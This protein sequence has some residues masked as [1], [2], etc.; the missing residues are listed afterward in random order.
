MHE[1]GICEVETPNGNKVRAYDIERS[2][3]DIIRSK[4]RMDLEQVKKVIRQYMKSKNKDMSKL[5]EYSNKMGIN[6][7]VMEL[8]GMFND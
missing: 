2:I 5:S 7:Q 6:K 1:L 3:C 4:N 8:V